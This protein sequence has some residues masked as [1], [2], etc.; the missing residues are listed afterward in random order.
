MR[1]HKQPVH[2]RKQEAKWTFDLDFRFS[3]NDDGIFERG[4][5]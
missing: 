1:R 3:G 5:K 2:L 4:A